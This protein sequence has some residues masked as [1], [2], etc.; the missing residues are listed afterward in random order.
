MPLSALDPGAALVV[1]DLQKGVT[2]LDV[3]HPV[4]RVVDRSA[5][6]AAAFRARGLPT[7]QSWCRNSAPN[8]ATIAWSSRRGAPSPGPGS[9]STP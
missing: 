4:E 7:G 8:P 3:A 1:V 6:L 2:R 5:A 9:P